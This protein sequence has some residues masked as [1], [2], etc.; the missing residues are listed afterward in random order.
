MRLTPQVMKQT[1]CAEAARDRKPHLQSVCRQQQ[2][3]TARPNGILD[4]KIDRPQLRI[5][6]AADGLKAKQ[7]TCFSIC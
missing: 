3:A 6:R 1:G 7:N 4:S 2:L 5:V